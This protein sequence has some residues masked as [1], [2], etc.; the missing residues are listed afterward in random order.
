MATEQVAIMALLLRQEG[1]LV[2]LTPTV[3]RANDMLA[4][5]HS[6]PKVWGHRKTVHNT[7]EGELPLMMWS[8]P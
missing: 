4:A 2:C 5:P 3:Q 7:W 8:G 6:R 1:V